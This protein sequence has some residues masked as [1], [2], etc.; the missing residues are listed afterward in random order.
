MNEERRFIIPC[1]TII[2]VAV[3]VTVATVAARDVMVAQ[4]KCGAIK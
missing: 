2:A 4:I 1:L 3:C